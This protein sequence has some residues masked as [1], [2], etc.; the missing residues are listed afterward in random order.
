MALRKPMKK[1]MS[2]RE[3]LPAALKTPVQGPP[4]G[5]QR[6]DPDDPILLLQSDWVEFVG[7][8]LSKNSHPVRLLRSSTGGILWVGVSSSVWANELEFQKNDLLD[9]IARRFKSL[10]LTDIRFQIVTTSS[11]PI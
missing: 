10:G 8:T 2:L 4:D 9:K 11:G 7:S 5:R 3:L 1:P 6:H